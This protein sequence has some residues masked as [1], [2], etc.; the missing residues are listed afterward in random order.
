MTVRIG[1]NPIIWTTD[2]TPRLAGLPREKTP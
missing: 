2:D 1:I